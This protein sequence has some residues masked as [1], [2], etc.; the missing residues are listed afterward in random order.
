MGNGIFSR[1]EADR[2]IN[3]MSSVSDI[4]RASFIDGMFGLNNVHPFEE[5]AHAW[6]RSASKNFLI[7]IFNFI[8]SIFLFII[9][10]FA[11]LLR[12]NFVFRM[13]NNAF[14][15]IIVFIIPCIIFIYFDNYKVIFTLLLCS[16]FIMYV[17]YKSKCI[18]SFCAVLLSFV[19]SMF[20]VV[21]VNYLHA[22]YVP[23]ENYFGTWMTE[24]SKFILKVTSKGMSSNILKVTNNSKFMHS[25]SYNYIFIYDKN[26][27]KDIYVFLFF[28][29][30][31]I[32]NPFSNNAKILKKA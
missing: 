3:G 24:D 6:A 10:S 22:I 9:L 8:L 32:Y 11:V 31:L 1:I 20:L 21:D 18:K 13:I 2:Y 7:K 12:K 15:I 17:L 27:K 4:Y 19:I 16:M 30:T 5:V 29:N 14:G 23:R 25:Y 26:N 28:N